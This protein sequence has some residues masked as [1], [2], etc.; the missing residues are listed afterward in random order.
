MGYFSNGTEALL[1]EEM[2]C[3][4]C[5]HNRGEHLCAVMQAHWDCASYP[6]SQFHVDGSPER[7]V[8]D[9][10]IPLDVDGINQECTM[11]MQIPAHLD[12]DWDIIMADY[13]KSII[14]RQEAEDVEVIKKP[15]KPH[16]ATCEPDCRR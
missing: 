10:F 15:T 16:P 4:Q 13:L 12:V 5:L 8:L 6:K 1:Y 14:A 9:T 3:E 7:M 11:L 2:Y